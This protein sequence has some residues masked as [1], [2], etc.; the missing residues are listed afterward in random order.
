MK[1]LDSSDG[2]VLDI[3]FEVQ[4][5]YG[6]PLVEVDSESFKTFMGER[7]WDFIKKL[8][9]HPVYSVEEIMV[10][11]GNTC[12]PIVIVSQRYYTFVVHSFGMGGIKWRISF[13]NKNEKIFQIT[14][15]DTVRFI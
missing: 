7:S 2:V 9:F 6:R 5:E 10:T 14:S 13:F 8:Y 4:E 3:K 15:R 1:K 12:D 11:K